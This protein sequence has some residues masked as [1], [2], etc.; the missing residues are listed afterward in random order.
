MERYFIAQAQGY[1]IRI[2][3]SSRTL[4]LLYNGSAVRSY[5]VAVGK[6]ATP[7][8]AGNFSIIE[9]RINPGGPFGA[10]WM[11]FYG[12]YGIHGT[13]NPSSIGKYISN[14]C[15]RMYNSDAIDLYNKVT[16]GTP[17]R[18]T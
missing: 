8:P 11:R 6:P 2:N 13:N 1:E 18:I 4:T 10:R 15:V 16:Y 17:V 14:G 9:K 5:P 3:R 12:G 7:T